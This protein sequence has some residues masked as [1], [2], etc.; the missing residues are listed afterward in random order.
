[1]WNLK[2]MVMPV[3]VRATGIVTKG[4]KKNLEANQEKIQ[5]IG[6]KRQSTESAAV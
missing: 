2:L 3:T 6:H 5:Q 4:L 1:M